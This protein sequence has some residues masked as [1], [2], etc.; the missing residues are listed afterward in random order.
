MFA[1]P[2]ISPPQDPCAGY[3][4]SI[5]KQVGS[6]ASVMVSSPSQIDWPLR[7]VEYGRKIFELNTPVHVLLSLDFDNGM[8]VCENKAL[9]ILAFGSDISKAIHS[10]SEDFEM[11]WDVI[12]QS[13]DDSL[14][15]E[16]QKVKREMLSIVNRIA[17][18]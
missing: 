15:S 10:F 16:A 1:P 13:P 5:E 11:M 9:S 4:S 14:T 6:S 12:A 8:W 7:E 3:V 18:R 2:P 17:T